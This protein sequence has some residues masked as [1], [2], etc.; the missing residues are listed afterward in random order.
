MEQ[1]NGQSQT[2][3]SRKQ[4]M[5]ELLGKYDK[6]SGMTVKA[7]CK[8]HQISEGSY[9]Y[10]LGRKRRRSSVT[11]IKK[12]GFIAIAQPVGKEPVSSLFAEVKGIKLYQ[13]VPADYLKALIA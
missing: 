3:G 11:S 6:K 8:L 9:Y 7:F 1:P 4:Q 5:L 2:F 13:A 12:S 10:Y